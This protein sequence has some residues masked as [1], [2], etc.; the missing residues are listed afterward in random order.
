MNSE[1]ANMFISTEHI[2]RDDAN[3]S[4]PNMALSLGVLLHHRR[5]LIL[6]EHHAVCDTVPFNVSQGL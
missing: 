3:F 4:R 2:L 1:S 6:F 5:P